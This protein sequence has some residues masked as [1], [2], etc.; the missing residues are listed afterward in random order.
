MRRSER[1]KSLGGPGGLRCPCCGGGGHKRLSNGAKKLKRDK[2]KRA[3]RKSEK[4]ATEDY[5]D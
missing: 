5:C 4:I 3:R 2:V 1:I